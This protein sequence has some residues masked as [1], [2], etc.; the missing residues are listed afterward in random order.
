M[1]VE[2]IIEN[3]YYCCKCIDLKHVLFSPSENEK[4]VFD[5]CPDFQKLGFHNVNHKTEI[6]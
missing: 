6:R 1:H 3:M 5:S 2:N 4:H